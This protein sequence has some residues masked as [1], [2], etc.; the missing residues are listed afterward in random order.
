MLDQ[1][2]SE[3]GGEVSLKKTKWMRVC[4]TQPEEVKESSIGVFMGSPAIDPSPDRIL[5]IRGAVVEELRSFAYLGSIV[6]NTAT[7]GVEE[8]IK[9]R[10]QKAAKAFGLLRGAWRSRL[11]SHK[12]K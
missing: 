12:T 1:I 6:G 11:L 5:V 7:L 8:D 10:I 4:M 3:F 9:N 2:V